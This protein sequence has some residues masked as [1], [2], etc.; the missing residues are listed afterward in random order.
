MADDEILLGEVIGVFG[1]R[2]ELRLH[3]YN[4][5]DS[6]LAE[7]RPV[8]LVDADGHRRAARMQVRSG[9]G[10]RVLG[11][12]PGV[13]TEEAARALQGVQIWI[14]RAELPPPEPGEFY[15]HDLIGADVVDAN[16]APQGTVV[17]I[18]PGER[19]VWVL[20]RDGNEAFLIAGPGVVQ[21]VDVAGKRV[22]VAVGAVAAED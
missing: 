22:V 14:A 8:T 7:E 19:D 6:S 5:E 13:D 11:R 18:V 4:R 15:V 1:F 16:G 21:E 12:I 2:G 9:A 3:L 17:E 10:K 20:E